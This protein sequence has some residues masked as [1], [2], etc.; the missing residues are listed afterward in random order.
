[1]RIDYAKVVIFLTLIH[2][3]CF[4]AHLESLDK[5]NFQDN[6]IVFL[7]YSIHK[8]A[9]NE[10]QVVLMN[11]IIVE[12]TLKQ[13]SAKK[14]LNVLGNL[15]CIELDENHREINTIYLLNPLQKPVEYV[16][17]EGELAWTEISQDESGFSIRL[18][19]HEN[20]AYIAIEQINDPTQ[21]GKRIITT[22]IE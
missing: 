14:H 8:S 4:A 18:Q 19:L 3:F 20:T 12:G 9:V 13:T 11:Q 2:S 22:K 6:K 21:Q 1:M 10:I 17:D 7:N 5:D 16:N 15:K